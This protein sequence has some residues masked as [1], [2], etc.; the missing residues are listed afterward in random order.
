LPATPS[1]KRA[2]A[3]GTLLLTLNLKFLWLVVPVPKAACPCWVSACC[4]KFVHHPISLIAVFCTL[5]DFRTCHVSCYT[6]R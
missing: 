1:K 5:F 6:T 2:A 3:S 4:L